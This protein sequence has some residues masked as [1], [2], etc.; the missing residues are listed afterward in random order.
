MKNAGWLF[1]GVFGAA[2]GAIVY[3]A[4]IPDCTER[5]AVKAMQQAVAVKMKSP[6]TATFPEKPTVK[7]QVECVYDVSGVVDSQNSFGAIVRSRYSGLVVG[8]DYLATP[9]VFAN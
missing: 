3:F 5:G 9:S 7:K 1:M 4:A 6:S 8:K 2:A